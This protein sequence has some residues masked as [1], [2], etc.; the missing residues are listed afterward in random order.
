MSKVTKVMP[1]F[2]GVA[3]GQ[4]A[5]VA[6]PI[7]LSYEQLMVSYAGVTLAQM[8]EIRLIGNGKTIQRWTSGSRLDAFN[9]FNGRAA[10]AGIL[11][12][13]F[14]RYGARTRA[15]EE[16]TVLGT[17]VRSQKGSIELS[18]LV[19]EIDIDAGAAAPVLSCK[20]VQSAPQPL[21]LIRHVREYTYGP[22]AAGDF[23]IS[24]IPK[25]HRFN[26]V[27]FLHA[28]VTDLR[29]EREGFTLFD[30]DKSENDL[31]QSDGIRV[32]VAGGFAFD[33]SEIGNGTE[34]MRTAG[35]HDLRFV[36]TMSGAAT[37][38][39]LVDSIAPLGA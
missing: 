2:N 22:S 36:C 31:I 15:A 9:T 13:D 39:V 21:G 34:V 26:Q 20:A 29:I 25:G 30:R 14:T 18:N 4:T 27:H 6:L 23:E 24:D 37:L 38:P 1:S 7:G 32:P 17:G 35:V 16:V 8:N 12:L 5:V 3:A 28:N 19:L 10:A 11:V 33:P